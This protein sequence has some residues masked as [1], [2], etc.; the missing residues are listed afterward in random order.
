MAGPAAQCRK[1][2]PAHRR[3]RSSRSFAR[4]LEPQA[5]RGTPSTTSQTAPCSQRTSSSSSGRRA[6][7]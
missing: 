7:L 3:V 2:H 6:T 4:P 5:A 1:Q